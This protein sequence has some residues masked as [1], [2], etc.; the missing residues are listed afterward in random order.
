MDTSE[1]HLRFDVVVPPEMF[2]HLLWLQ[3]VLY[4]LAITAV[5]QANPTGGSTHHGGGRKMWACRW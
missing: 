5:E 4:L 1:D 2:D 3:G